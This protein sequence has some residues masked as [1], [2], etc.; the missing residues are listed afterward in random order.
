MC[1]V[2]IFQC[3]KIFSEPK[4]S[5][6]ESEHGWEKR[7][8]DGERTMA[9]HNE[10]NIHYKCCGRWNRAMLCY[11]NVSRAATLRIMYT[12][13]D[14]TFAT[15]EREHSIALEGQTNVISMWFL[16]HNNFSRCVRQL[17]S[18]FDWFVVIFSLLL[19][20]FHSVSSGLMFRLSQQASVVIVNKQGM[21]KI[22]INVLL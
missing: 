5:K 15:L 4:D 19:L 12:M 17:L 13:L 1:M 14:N 10:H 7:L 3:W 18:W 20:L 16:V 8:T 11:E 9:W 22:I 6:L 2:F 21:Y